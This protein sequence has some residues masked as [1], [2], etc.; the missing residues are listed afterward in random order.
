M[1]ALIAS[2]MFSV[3][4]YLALYEHGELSENDPVELLR[5]EIVSKMTLGSVHMAFVKKLNRL[6]QRAA[7]DE[8]TIGVQDAVVV[9]D[10]VPEPDISLLQH[11]DDFYVTGHPT[12][13]DV[14]LLIEVADTSLDFDR[15]VKGPLYAEGGVPEYWIVNLVEH[16]VEVF[17]SP[18]A[19]GTFLISFVARHG[20]QLVVPGLTH[21]RLDVSEIC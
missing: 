18:Q 10:S 1:N 5:G 16:C 15:N 9:L 20:D 14:L 12:A 3:T 8:V 13:A 19:D 11:R 21:I 2:Q 17:R 6:L 4:E 7:G